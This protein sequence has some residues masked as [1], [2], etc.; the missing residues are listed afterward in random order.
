MRNYLRIQE[1]RFPGQLIPE[2]KAPE[3]LLNTPVPPLV[4]QTFV[5]NAVKHAITLDDPVYLYI[6]LEMSEQ[7]Q[8]GIQIQIRDT[9][10]GFQ[11]EIIRKINQ[12]ERIVDEDGEHIG[13]R[14]LK[15]RLRLLYHGL[16][17]V[18]LCN[19]VPHGASVGITLPFAP[20]NHTN[21]SPGGT[22]P[23]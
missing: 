14:N 1:L 15:Q 22:A 23:C 6:E 16:G 2:I 11:D 4:I 7:P 3:F 8:A 20:D 5:E 18:T 12:E 21:H 17:E 10:P 9:G 13:I 19:A